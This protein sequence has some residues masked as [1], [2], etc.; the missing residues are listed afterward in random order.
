M[1]GACWVWRLGLSFSLVSSIRN[2]EN[3][4]RGLESEK[5]MKT[6]GKDGKAG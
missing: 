1:V 2:D 6:E 5:G 4:Q 3:S